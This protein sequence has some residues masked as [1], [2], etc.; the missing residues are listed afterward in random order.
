IG[1]GGFY[2]ALLNGSTS[3]RVPRITNG[4]FSPVIEAGLALSIGG[5][6]TIDKGIL[7]AGATITVQAVLQGVFGWF[8]PNDSSA[9]SALYYWIQGKAAIVGKSYGPFVFNIFRADISLLTYS[10]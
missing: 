4:N 2:F 1:Y 8:N 7:S 6:R 3:E 9:P 10:S 5:G